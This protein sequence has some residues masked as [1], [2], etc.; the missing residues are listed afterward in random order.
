MPKLLPFPRRTVQRLAVSVLLLT[1]SR[2]RLSRPEP[3]INRPR[4]S[5]PLGNMLQ[6][7]ARKR[8][9]AVLVLES[10]VADLLELDDP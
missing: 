3:W 8:P 2:E 1:A 9:V 6:R 4:P 7:L 10:I 5:E